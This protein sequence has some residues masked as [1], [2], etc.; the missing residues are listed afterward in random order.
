[1]SN[2]LRIICMI[3]IG[4]LIVGCANVGVPVNEQIIELEGQETYSLADRQERGSSDELL[5]ILS[6][7][8]GGTRAAALSYGVM[9]ELRNI[10]AFIDG[11]KTRLLDEI[12]VISSVSGGS[13]TSAYYGLK[14]DELFENYEADFLR[15]DLQKHLVWRAVNPALL[16]SSRGR[17]DSAIEYY[18]D[19]LFDNATFADMAHPE[20]PLIIINAS[21]LGYGVRFSFVQEYFDLL[22]SD[23]SSYPVANAVAASSAVPVV[24]TPVV[25]ANHDQCSNLELTGTSRVRARLQQSGSA[26]SPVLL[27]QLDS[28][29]DKEIRQYIHLVDGGITDNLG[30]RA[31]LDILTVAGG[32]DEFSRRHGQPAP[33]KVVIIMVDANTQPNTSMNLSNKQPS[34]VTVISAVSGLQLARF[35]AEGAKILSE[36]IQEWESEPTT[37]SQHQRKAHFVKVR[38]QDIQDP[39]TRSY[40]NNVPTSFR[41]EDNQVD[42]L[43]EA[44]RSLLRDNHEF[45]ELLTGLGYR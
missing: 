41:L 44:G 14:G 17:T 32:L 20:R 19:V 25:L 13:F 34:P 28:Y 16:F 26:D 21:D 37:P 24:F 42:R 35:D 6:F 36:K 31:I 7:S 43:I 30:V 2:N 9:Q 23:L 27:S 11:R 12:D 45:Q 18:Q 22:C 29:S 38:L 33:Q 3:L 39:E 10:E 15:F 5:F 8:G 4:I 1:M 40:F